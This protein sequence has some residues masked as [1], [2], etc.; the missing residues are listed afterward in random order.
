[1]FGS[2]IFSRGPTSLV[3]C[4][5]KDR[6]IHT[7]TAVLGNQTDFYKPPPLTEADMTF[8]RDLAGLDK[9]HPLVRA[10]RGL[11]QQLAAP[12]LA[13]FERSQ[14]TLRFHELRGIQGRRRFARRR[15]EL[16]YFAR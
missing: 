15:D 10:P 16:C 1:M 6:L 8:L 2:S 3:G 9:A 11:F 5:Q 13:A 7:A 4:P 12:S 14:L